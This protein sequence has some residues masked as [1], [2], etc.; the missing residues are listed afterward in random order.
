LREMLR[1]C[2]SRR[3]DAGVGL[4][5]VIVGTLAVLILGFVLM[6]VI[7]LGWAVYKLNSATGDIADKLGVGRT[8]A[9]SMNQTVSVLFDSEG[10]R[11]GIDRN[12]NGRL[13]NIEA[14]ELPAGVNLSEDAVVTFTR[15]GSLAKG[16]RQPQIVVANSRGSR[17]VR[18]SSMGSVEID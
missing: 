4:M 12:G 3:G 2:G 7:N 17:L 11:Y 1:P 10:G 15:T 9:M 8:A 18:V 5:E 6:H 14:E 13:D 16:S